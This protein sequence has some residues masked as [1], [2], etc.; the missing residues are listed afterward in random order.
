MFKN[1]KQIFAIM[2][3]VAFCTVMIC[4]DVPVTKAYVDGKGFDTVIKTGKVNYIELDKVAKALG[5]TYSGKINSSIKLSKDGSIIVYKMGKLTGASK[6]LINGKTVKI[7]PFKVYKSKVMI[8]TTTLKIIF[9]VK[10]VEVKNGGI[11][12]TVNESSIVTGTTGTNVSPD[13]GLVYGPDVTPTPSVAPT[14][15]LKPVVTPKPTP[16]P[17]PVITAA[18]Y[19][20]LSNCKNLYKYYYSL[21][22]KKDGTVWYYDSKVN[23]NAYLDSI[24]YKGHTDIDVGKAEGIDSEGF[25]VV[26]PKRFW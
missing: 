20:D 6:I 23:K 12:I 11:Y 26:P 14:P 13:D 9:N 22:G 21:L 19:P 25:L 17:T 1:C 15:T 4:A 8:N 2:L 18:G 10:A 16:E 7:D 5:Y 24:T 3:V